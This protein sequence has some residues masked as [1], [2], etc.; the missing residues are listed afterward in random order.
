MGIIVY[1]EIN[2]ANTVQDSGINDV[3]NDA[4]P[5]NHSTWK[6]EKYITK[7]F[8]WA[9]AEQAIQLYSQKCTMKVQMMCDES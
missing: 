9:Q 4:T 6:V 8:P 3:A 2:L 1:N 7:T 5:S